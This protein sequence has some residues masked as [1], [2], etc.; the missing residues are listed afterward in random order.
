MGIARGTDTQT[1]WGTDGDA[2]VVEPV[3]VAVDNELWWHSKVVT[4]DQSDVVR[5][6]FVNAHTD[7][8][9]IL[10]ETDEV[11]DFIAGTDVEELDGADVV[12]EEGEEI[13]TEPQP[14]DPDV[15]YHIVIYDED[16]EEIDR[17]E[18]EDGQEINIEPN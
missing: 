15:A 2:L 6:I 9:V 1:S 8:A 12:D 11:Y 17:I 4:P 18:V 16:G 3:P 5:N 13:E 7:E 14:D 10:H